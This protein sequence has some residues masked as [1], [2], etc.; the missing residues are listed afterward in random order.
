V[1]DS[2]VRGRLLQLLFER[3]NEGPLPFGAAD[4]AVQPP[5]GVDLRDWLHALARLVET[6]LVSWKPLPD[7]SG[8]GKM[9]GL[10]E[11]TESGVDVHDGR[12]TPDLDIRFMSEPD[13]P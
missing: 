1:K 4:G 10:A 9:C 13:W 3:R 11:I 5:A 7:L 8:R 2:I 12:E 6:G